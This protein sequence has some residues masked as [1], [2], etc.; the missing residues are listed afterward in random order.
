[1]DQSALVLMQ[2][3]KI[4]A[5]LIWASQSIA[6]AD[7]LEGLH[8]KGAETIIRCL[9]GMIDGE[10]NLARRSAPDSSW[11][12]VQKHIDKALVMINSGVFHDAPWHLTQALTQVTRICQT[13]MRDLNDKG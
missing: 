13:A 12:S 6:V 2:A 4:K 5:G 10:V 3:E 8:R 11:L 9:V 7:G 1:M